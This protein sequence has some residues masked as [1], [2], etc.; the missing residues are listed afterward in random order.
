MYNF[1]LLAIK[2]KVSFL[3][4]AK[5]VGRSAVLVDTNSESIMMDYG[6]K[7]ETEPPRFPR[8][9]DTKL[10]AVILTHAHLDHVG[11]VPLLFRKGQNCPIYSM[12]ITSPL[13]R[14]L[15]FDSIKIA[16]HENYSLGY[17]E[18]DAKAALKN[19]KSFNYRK[20]FNIGNSK[21]TAYDAGHIAGSSMILLENQKK[22][23]YTGDFKLEDTRL[24]KGA[25]T[26]IEDV[27]A[28]VIES[29]YS[30]RDHPNRSEEERKFIEHI[31]S[32]L[33]NEGVA[34]VASFAISR[35]QETLLVL[36]EFEVNYPVY[37]DGMSAN[38][39]EIL[40]A[41]PELQREYNILK[42]VL[43]RMNVQFV[44]N[45]NMRKKIIKKPCVIICGSGMLSGGPVVGYIKK[46]FGREDC[47]LSLTGFQSPGT[48]GARLLETGKFTDEEVDLTV[49]MSVKRFNFSS[50]ASRTELLKLCKKISP[51]K[52]FCIHGDKTEEFA[53]ELKE[54]HGFDAISPDIQKKYEI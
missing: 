10:S 2:L 51:E 48:G 14:I 18:K 13:S 22:L 47:S 40:D 32:T 42:K 33:N 28:L 43:Q 25:D 31:R 30:D 1:I 36:D 8:L 34:L 29:T 5:E 4:G 6:L 19:F 23:L 27:D 45:V 21:I 9:P 15:F 11:A 38:A 50:H 12:E 39:T 3:G 7:I 53:N 17:S 20:P 37:L 46:M 16:K 26:D 41:Y 35:S 44:D 49:K 54:V 52:I 24:M